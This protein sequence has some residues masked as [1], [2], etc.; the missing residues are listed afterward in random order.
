MTNMHKKGLG[1][2]LP[3]CTVAWLLA[4]LPQS[5]KAKSVQILAAGPETHCGMLFGLHEKT[6]TCVGFLPPSKNHLHKLIA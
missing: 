6:F 4:L 5:K 3:G 1:L 2:K